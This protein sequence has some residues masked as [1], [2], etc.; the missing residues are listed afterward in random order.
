[1]S[2]ECY[3][4]NCHL[5]DL[6]HVCALWHK[7]LVQD[8]RKY[9]H[10]RHH[11]SIVPT[12]LGST[13]RIIFLHFNLFW[14]KSSIGCTSSYIFLLFLPISFPAYFFPLSHQHFYSKNLY[15]KAFHY[16]RHCLLGLH[17]SKSFQ[18]SFSYFIIYL[19]NA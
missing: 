9:Y 8:I 6:S 17:M 13:I 15:S 19:C 3:L 7:F 12:I 2:F 11:Q 10:H 1:M 5:G 4:N 18:T 14:V 16:Q